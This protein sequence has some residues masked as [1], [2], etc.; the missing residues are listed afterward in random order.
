MK[1]AMKIV[2]FMLVVLLVL[3]IAA[4]SYIR[5]MLPSGDGN[6]DVVEGYYANFQSDALM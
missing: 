1:K 4:S 5:S 3:G 2:L 6:N